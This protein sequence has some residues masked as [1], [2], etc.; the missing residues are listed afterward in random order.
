MGVERDVTSIFSTI[1]ESVRKIFLQPS[2]M[3]IGDDSIFKTSG[4]RIVQ[5]RVGVELE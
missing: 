1:F 5:T 3:E 2:K 4:Y